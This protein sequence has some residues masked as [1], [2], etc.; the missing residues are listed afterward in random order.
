MFMY[1]SQ[2]NFNLN[3]NKMEIG[4]AD[5]LVVV[6]VLST[7]CHA[8]DYVRNILEDIHDSFKDITFAI[9]NI[10]KN[11]DLLEKFNAVNINVTHTPTY[12]L[13]KLGF[14]E[15]ILDIKILSKDSLTKSLK[16]EL[17]FN[18]IIPKQDDSLSKY[19]KLY[20]F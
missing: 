20:Q 11:Y 5:S 7:T 8:C 15:R 17:N 14:F 16:N 10:D 6:C 1:L 13:F 18:R 12:L 2:N 19:L 3:K 4:T 9:I